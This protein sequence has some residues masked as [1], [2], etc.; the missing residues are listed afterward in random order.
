MIE[1]AD[2]RQ[3]IRP[4]GCL[5]RRPGFPQRQLAVAAKLQQNVR[6]GVDTLGER[7]QRGNRRRPVRFRRGRNRLEF[8]WNDH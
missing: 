8:A 3:T 4:A 1:L 7:K 2:H 5:E 6:I